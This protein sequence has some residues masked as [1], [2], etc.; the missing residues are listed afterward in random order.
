[1]AGSKFLPP[2]GNRGF[3][4][5]GSGTTARTA[6][7][8]RG[9]R[10]GRGRVYATPRGWIRRRRS[11]SSQQY[12][13]PGGRL[14]R[15]AG[16]AQA[17]HLPICRGGV[18]I[19]HRA[20]LDRGC[21]GVRA[22]HHGWK[23]DCRGPGD[24]PDPLRSHPPGGRAVH[25]ERRQQRA[26]FQQLRCQGNFAASLPAKRS[27]AET[28]SWSPSRQPVGQPHRFVSARVSKLHE[29]YC[30]VEEVRTSNVRGP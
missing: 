13:L 17:F 3:L 27:P 20:C 2:C 24:N 21:P 4:S 1:M 12:S 28:L 7:T 9:S 15:R 26:V 16:Q 6:G 30:D 19:R 8:V 23:A 14:R 10:S 22:A 5:D 29:L 18:R 11:G 25:G